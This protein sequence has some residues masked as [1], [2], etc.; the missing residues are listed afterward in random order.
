MRTHYFE[1]YK[2][3]F[4]YVAAHY[5]M[6]GN[7]GPQKVRDTLCHGSSDDPTMSTACPFPMG[8]TPLQVSHFLT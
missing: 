7:E 1:N 2:W 6:G 5:F 3:K 8:G 4:D